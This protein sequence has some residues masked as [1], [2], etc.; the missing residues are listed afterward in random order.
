M[1]WLLQAAFGGEPPPPPPPL[2][3]DGDWSLL[4]NDADNQDEDSG[5]LKQF[6]LDAPRMT[7]GVDGLRWTGSA[8]ELFSLVF[9][10]FLSKTGALLAAQFCTQTALAPYFCAVQERL[11][12]GVHF[13][14]GGRQHIQFDS[15]ASRLDVEKPFKV[16]DFD[17]ELNARVL[18]LVTL[19]IQV[20]LIT[21]VALHWFYQSEFEQDWVVLEEEGEDG[22]V[23]IPMLSVGPQDIAARV[24]KLRAK[25]PSLKL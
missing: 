25:L 11:E 1:S 15:L 13:V 24:V 17:S 22:E 8:L 9:S 7:I 5:I 6:L 2:G 23:D 14:D 20:N 3:E 18:F 4:P 10:R 16:V 19:K 12:A 21:E